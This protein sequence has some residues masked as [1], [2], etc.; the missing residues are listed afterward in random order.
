MPCG[1]AA[2]TGAQ[3]TFTEVKDGISGAIPISNLSEDQK[4]KLAIAS[5]NHGTWNDLFINNREVTKEEAI[6]EANEGSELGNELIRLTMMGYE[7]IYSRLL[8]H[9]KEEYPNSERT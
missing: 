7:H 5:W 4:R 3:L 1:F 2:D 9:D 8:P 6:S